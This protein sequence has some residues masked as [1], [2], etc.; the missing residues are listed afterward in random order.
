MKEQK[1]NELS[2]PLLQNQLKSLKVITYMLSG[3][4]L[5]L[6]S[7]IIYLT[8]K[9]GFNAL[10]IVPI[11]L[12]PILILNFNTMNKLKKELKLRDYNN[13]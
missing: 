6:F 5:F 13:Y 7:L 8:I 12:L 2:T 11:A 9:N 1:L 3:T 4:L 10:T